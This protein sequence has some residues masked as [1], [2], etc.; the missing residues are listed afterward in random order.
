MYKMEVFETKERENKSYIP[1]GV[2]S[3]SRFVNI[4][5]FLDSGRWN[6]RADYSLGA[7]HLSS[8][9]EHAL[10]RETNENPALAT[11]RTVLGLSTSSARFFTGQKLTKDLY[12]AS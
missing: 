9:R 7:S 6:F 12:L 4:V 5:H 11:S 10:V 2:Y 3:G 1:R 8:D